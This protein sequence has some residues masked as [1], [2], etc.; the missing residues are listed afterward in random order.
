MILRRGSMTSDR[1]LDC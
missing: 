1:W